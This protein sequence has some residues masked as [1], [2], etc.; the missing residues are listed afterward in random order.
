MYDMCHP[1]VRDLCPWIV[2]RVLKLKRGGTTSTSNGS[3]NPLAV[4]P[5]HGI[6]KSI[7]DT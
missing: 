6:S 4:G 3:G 5:R 1:L 7:F 2:K